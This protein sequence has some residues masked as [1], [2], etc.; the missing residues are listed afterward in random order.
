[1]Q[2]ETI[3]N[4]KKKNCLKI[5]NQSKTDKIGQEQPC[6]R[7]IL[8]FHATYMIE[9]RPDWNPFT[10]VVLTHVCQ[11]LTLN[12]KRNSCIKKSI[13]C[14][15]TSLLQSWDFFPSVLQKWE[16]EAYTK[17]LYQ[18]YHNTVILSVQQQQKSGVFWNKCY[19]KSLWKSDIC[20]LYIPT[21][22][23]EILWWAKPSFL[24]LDLSETLKSLTTY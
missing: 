13:R 20:T 15:I 11:F 14:K 12:S 16:K 2:F 5:S 23:D 24:R 3:L 21:Y 8:N 9:I 4:L 18:R 22:F 10:A 7:K 17:Q 6:K 19:M 1:M